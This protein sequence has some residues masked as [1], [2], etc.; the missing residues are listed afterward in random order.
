M[1]DFSPFN[2]GDRVLLATPQLASVDPGLFVRTFRQNA[3]MAT[4]A[5]SIILSLAFTLVYSVTYKHK[6][7]SNAMMYALVCIL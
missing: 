2:S 7:E 3:W 4:L 1:M 5:T 6:K